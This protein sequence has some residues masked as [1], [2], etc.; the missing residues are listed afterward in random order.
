MLNNL[1]LF[2]NIAIELVETLNSTLGIWYLIILNAFGVIAII[3]KICEY[4]VKSRGQMFMLSTIANVCWV[5]YFALYGNFASALT[6]TI[7]VAKLLIFMQ[8]GRQRWADSIWWLILFL[9][10]QVFVTVFTV[11]SWVDVFCVTAGFLGIF[12]YFFKSARTYRILS[13]LHMSVWVANSIFNFYLIALLSDSFSTVSCGIAIYRFDIKKP[14]KKNQ[15]LLK[16]KEKV[17]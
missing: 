5:L 14:S 15:K 17:V 2:S 10:C 12:A 6:C 8:K 4:Q 16:A 1:G 3:C 13:F 9:V 11:S 7:N